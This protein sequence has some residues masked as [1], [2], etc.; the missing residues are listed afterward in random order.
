M[1]EHRG[2]IDSSR[3]ALGAKSIWAGKDQ[4]KPIRPGS[5]GARDNA[6]ARS[7]MTSPP[8]EETHRPA[9]LPG[10]G[11][12]KQNSH[13]HSQPRLLVP[14]LAI[15]ACVIVAGC[16]SSTAPSPTHRPVPSSSPPLASISRAT[17]SAGSPA[18]PLRLSCRQESFTSSPAPQQPRPAD[19]AIGPLII[20]NGK[21]LATA[22]PAGFGYRGHYKIPLIV[23]MGSTVTVTIAA[24][25][26]GQVVI[27]NPYAQ[28][29]GIRGLT[30]AT[31]RSCS[32]AAGFF[33]QGFAFTHG[34]TR[35]CVP[36]DVKIGHQPQV[37]RVTLSLFAGS[38][39][40]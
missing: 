36:L 3:A 18:N 28:M 30:A 19:L 27:D 20:I 2:I 29:W 12:I 33:A 22:K 37:H 38:C 24:P 11:A 17:A 15:L 34:Q 40:S 14:A 35:G 4:P 16:A 1:P 23:T 9:R 21:L 32:R 5:S 13:M 10:R 8:H 6:W 31:Y 7:G 25:A 26:R 39:S